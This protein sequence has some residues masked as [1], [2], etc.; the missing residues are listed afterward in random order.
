MTDATAITHTQAPRQS[1][2][3]YAR[4]VYL[5][6]GNALQPKKLF[7]AFTPLRAILVTSVLLHRGHLNWSTDSAFA[8]N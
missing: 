2:Q 6:L 7:P 5:H 1:D 8:G 3:A 4:L